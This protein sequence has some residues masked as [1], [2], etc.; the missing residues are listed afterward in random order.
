VLNKGTTGTNFNN[1]FGMT[2]S[3]T[4]DWTRDLPH[5]KP[6]L[7]Q[8][9]PWLKSENHLCYQC[10]HNLLFCL[11]LLPLRLSECVRNLLNFNEHRL[12]NEMSII[13]TICKWA[14]VPSIQLSPLLRSQD[15]TRNKQNHY[16]LNCSW[17][18]FILL[19]NTLN[20]LEMFD[21]WT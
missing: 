7:Y 8:Y 13:V 16:V 15:E 12:W 4:G 11:C 10:Q 21:K 1:I 2:R 6:A 3:L 9:W 19:D 18:F 5:S 17:Y 14:N 20:T